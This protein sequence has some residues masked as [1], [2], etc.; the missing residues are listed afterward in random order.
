MARTAAACSTP[1]SGEAAAGT[2]V[3]QAAPRRTVGGQGLRHLRRGAGRGQ[4]FEFSE[5]E[6]VQALK[7]A[8]QQAPGLRGVGVQ[9]APY[10][11]AV[12]GRRR[13]AEGRSGLGDLLFRLGEAASRAEDRQPAVAVPG[14]PPH[15]RLFLPA[16]DDRHRRVRRGLDTGRGEPEELTGVIDRLAAGQRA[17]HVQALV[18]PAATGGRVD[19]AVADLA[20]VF[21]GHP[22]AERQPAGRQ[23]ADR[24]EGGGACVSRRIAASTATA[25]GSS[26]RSGSP[27]RTRERRPSSA[28]AFRIAARSSPFI[29]A[30][31]CWLSL[32]GGV[33]WPHLLP[34]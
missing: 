20:A 15:G 17:Q 6:M 24:G 26:I 27:Y 14:S 19:P 31:G 32:A 18:H 21:A 22:D 13:P 8:G 33:V 5:R 25:A 30:G 10:V 16:D 7:L 9:P 4:P 2:S 23:L 3:M 1:A 29:A 12:P 34:W 11:D 28:P